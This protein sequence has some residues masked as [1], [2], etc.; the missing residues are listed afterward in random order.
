MSAPARASTKLLA[1]GCRE[2]IGGIRLEK[3]WAFDAGDLIGGYDKKLRRT[4]EVFEHGVSA[5]LPCVEVYQRARRGVAARLLIGYALVMHD[6]PQRVRVGVRLPGRHSP[7]CND[8][9][10]CEQ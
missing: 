6:C 8:E 1:P 10:Q 5:T 4:D 2:E 3:D 9:C 7:G